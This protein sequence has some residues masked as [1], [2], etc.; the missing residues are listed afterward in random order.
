MDELKVPEKASRWTDEEREAGIVATQ[1]ETRHETE[2]PP[3]PDWLRIF[4]PGTNFS[5]EGWTCAVRHVGFEGGVWMM[6]VEPLEYKETRSASRSEFRRLRA[7]VG[8]KEAKKLLS[9]RGLK[10]DEVEAVEAVEVEEDA[11]A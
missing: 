2:R 9:A 5:H 7:Q 11:G 4:Q 8:K 1:T 3:L 10:M 6:L